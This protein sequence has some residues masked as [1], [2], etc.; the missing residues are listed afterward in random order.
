M[1]YYVLK[2]VKNGNSDGITTNTKFLTREEAELQ[3]DLRNKRFP[4]KDAKII[5]F[6]KEYD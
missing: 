2:L 1:R 4:R 6:E 3:A 5:V